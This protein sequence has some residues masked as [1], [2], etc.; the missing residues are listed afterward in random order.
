MTS[1][2]TH[3]SGSSG[4]LATPFQ[5]FST[6]ELVSLTNGTFIISSSS[7]GPANTLNGLQGYIWL[8]NL[9]TSGVQ[10]T[11]GANLAGW[12]LHADNAGNFEVFSTTGAGNPRPPDFIIPL[13]S[14]STTMSTSGN[15]FAVGAPPL[16]YGFFKVGLQ[17]NAGV[18]LS[19]QVGNLFI[20]PTA[21]DAV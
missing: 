12:F 4:Y 8:A 13:P 3:S 15:Y 19:A 6:T 10:Q 18:T 11:A 2:F 16:P 17:N 14:T 7:Y 1:T 21:D 9:S 20:G 5:V